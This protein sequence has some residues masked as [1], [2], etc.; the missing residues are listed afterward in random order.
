[1][2]GKILIRITRKNELNGYWIFL[3]SW[4]VI[5]GV[6]AFKV[7]TVLEVLL[8][9]FMSLIILISAILYQGFEVVRE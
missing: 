4:A 6:T 7:K 1:M 2:K 8:V 9:M 5:L 3:I